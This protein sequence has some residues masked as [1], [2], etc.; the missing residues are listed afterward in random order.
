MELPAPGTILNKYTPSFK[1]QAEGEQLALPAGVPGNERDDSIT[2]FFPEWQKLTEVKNEVLVGGQDRSSLSLMWDGFRREE[3][4]RSKARLEAILASEHPE[5]VEWMVEF[6][7]P[8]RYVFGSEYLLSSCWWLVLE[9]LAGSTPRLDQICVAPAKIP[10]DKPVA[11]GKSAKTKKTID[12]NARCYSREDLWELVAG[13][14]L[15]VS[16]L[17]STEKP[18]SKG[19][20]LPPRPWVIRFMGTKQRTELQQAEI[21]MSALDGIGF[22]GHKLEVNFSPFAAPQFFEE[23]E[24]SAANKST[25][26]APPGLD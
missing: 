1:D 20:S 18:R 24:E 7:K 26:S 4:R 13:L 8:F 17:F 10:I 12:N 25:S 14:N 6:G 22:F 2:Q 5:I 21:A 11:E 15:Q 9:F 19:K 23:E 16:E 3:E